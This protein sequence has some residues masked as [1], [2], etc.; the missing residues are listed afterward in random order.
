MYI[1]VFE[2]RESSR[3]YTVCY[4]HNMQS[5]EPGRMFIDN[6]AHETVRINENSL[7]HILDKY[8]KAELMKKDKDM[9]EDK[10]MMDKKIKE[11]E[12]K[13]KKSDLK[14]MKEKMKKKK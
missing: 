3:C 14:M 13:D 12:K 1:K 4:V 10:K 7:F 8:F 9:K 5:I 6:E 11:S 2:S